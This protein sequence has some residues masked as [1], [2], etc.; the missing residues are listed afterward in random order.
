MASI[1]QFIIYHAECP[2]GF[3]AAWSAF[4]LYND[5]A[6]YYAGVYG[7]QPPNVEGMEVFLLDFCYQYDVMVQLIKTAHSV[8]I[9]DHHKTSKQIVDRLLAD[10]SLQGKFDMDKS[11][12][13]LA[14]EHFNPDKR[15][16]K[17]LKHIQDYDLW[18]FN[19]KGTKEVLAAVNSYPQDFELWNT[20]EVH[21]LK[22]EGLPILRNHLKQSE[23]LSRS[24]STL[25]IGGYDVLAVNCGRAY[26]DDVGDILAKGKSF[27]AT[28]YH[29]GQRI[30]FSLRS[31]KKGADVSDIAALYGGGGH[32][33]AAGFS[34]A[35]FAQ[36]P[37]GALCD[38]KKGSKKSK[39]RR[40]N[41][42][43]VKPVK[44][45]LITESIKGKPPQTLIRRP[46]EPIPSQ[47]SVVRSERTG[48]YINR[49]IVKS[50][51]T[52]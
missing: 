45:T 42:K 22:E 37:F 48:L 34:I 17:L 3:G 30:I 6:K 31:D 4:Q 5:S 40:R 18:K 41:K 47:R 33:H 21:K 25:N 44:E 9:L 23:T 11:G 49:T 28:W 43:V 14:W 27:A 7:K 26:K 50:T 38:I 29:D 46:G 39:L 8:T 1:K 16:P 52:K 15:V 32:K 2:D 13:V 36:D 24:Y 12:A 10:G 35:N 51:K 20:F 19:I